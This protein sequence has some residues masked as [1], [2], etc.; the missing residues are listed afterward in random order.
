MITNSN[1]PPERH[2]RLRSWSRISAAHN[3][4]R[5]EFD[6]SFRPVHGLIHFNHDWDGTD[7][8]ATIAYNYQRQPS[9][10]N[11]RRASSVHDSQILAVAFPLTC[12]RVPERKPT[13]SL[14]GSG[15]LADVALVSS[16]HQTPQPK[17]GQQGGSERAK[18][19]TPSITGSEL[20]I[21]VECLG[22]MIQ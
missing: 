17:S 15:P 18:E 1:V 16:K 9:D 20:S 6:I 7:I 21:A 11:L 4:G 14:V 10:R 5:L 22:T 12:L 3:N 8:N 2:R 19:V 13:R